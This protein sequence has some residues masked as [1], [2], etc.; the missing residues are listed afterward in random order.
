MRA[1]PSVAALSLLLVL[2]V[3]GSAAEEQSAILGP[4][5][6]EHL[7]HALYDMNMTREDMGFTRDV[8]DPVLVLTNAREALRHPLRLPA[9]GD[10]LLAV[11]QDIAAG[12]TNTCWPLMAEW[13]DTFVDPP[14]TVSVDNR[15]REWDALEYNLA[16]LISAFVL[17]AEKAQGMLRTAYAEIPASEQCHMAASLLGD[18]FDAEDQPEVRRE[19][20][21]LGIPPATI[22]AV[23][24]ENLALD[25]KP[26]ATNY[27]AQ[28][29]AIDR[30]A[31]L[32]A[33][34]IMQEAVET[35]MQAQTN[36]TE[37]PEEVV[38]FPSMLGDIYIG[39]RGNDHY[40]QPAFLIVDPGGNDIYGDGCA[41]ANGLQQH[42]LSAVL[43]IAGNDRYEGVSITG[44]GAA[45]FGVAVILDAAGNDHHQCRYAGQGAGLFG[46][47]ILIDRAG[48]DFY[49]A[50]AL[51]QGA[52]YVGAGLLM[53]YGGN[54]VYKAGLA[55]QGYSGLLGFGLLADFD[56]NDYYLAGGVKPDYERH[57]ERFVSLAQGFSIGMR[58]FAGGGMAALVDLKGNDTYIADV[59]GQGVA[60]WYAVGMLL[61]A[62]G[63]D[64][65]A[66]HHY[67]QGSGIHLSA[68]LLFD[69]DGHDMYTGYILAQG[70]AH[71][72][73]VGMLVDHAGN[74]TY[75]ADHHSQG[76]ALN[77]ALGLLIDSGGDDA[78]FARQN[79]QSQ[80]I[81]NDGDKREYG[82]LALLLDLDGTDQ[83][84][85]GAE[86]GARL[87][88][89]DF[90][91]VYDVLPE[92]ETENTE[93]VP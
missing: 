4:E 63:C 70:N 11:T 76:R 93:E 21:F 86:D 66:M 35:F 53:D 83:Y 64:T 39:T 15:S 28:V 24:D 48:D 52:G 29:A 22:Q 10:T 8:A 14:G 62:E 73:A 82:S 58:P 30:H 9:M 50:Q 51:A 61:D 1:P 43:D 38:T 36:V 56:G 92:P 34:W 68:G 55:A 44:P 91:I 77:N 65:Y 37:W 31:I 41:R 6:M 59:Y 27:I 23:I 71:D 32:T 18:M 72:Y 75:S 25:P 33:A 85:C 80:G 54:D 81:G 5:E 13:L 47:S 16:F 42:W 3:A 2:L 87:L 17:K 7:D 46:A 12:G 67:G 60:Y 19:L 78:Y 20:T 90:G 88:R 49:S 45:L 89:P 40:T 57:P 69:G 74:D 84:S 26:A 79:E